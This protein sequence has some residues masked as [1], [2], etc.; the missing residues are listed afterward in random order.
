MILSFIENNNFI[1]KQDLSIYRNLF[2][3]F[4]FPS[5]FLFI[6]LR[7]LFLL[8]Y[9]FFL[10]VFLVFF[11][12]F[13]LLQDNVSLINRALRGQFVLPEFQDFVAEIDDMYWKQKTNIRGKV[14]DYIPQVEEEEGRQR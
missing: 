8:V 1:T 4:L 10:L 9:L 14:A 3:L 2:L 5:R 12:L 13:L 11:L 7:F 6:F